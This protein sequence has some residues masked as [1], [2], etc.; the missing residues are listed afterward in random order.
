[1]SRES[2][3]EALGQSIETVQRLLLGLEAV[4][5]DLAGRLSQC[6]GSSRTFWVNRETRYRADS[7]RIRQREAAASRETWVRQF[8]VQDMVRLGWIG[9]FQSP[10]EAAEECLKLFGVPDVAAWQARFAG[11]AASAAF[12]I[13]AAARANPGA[14]TAWLRWAE[15]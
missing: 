1:I 11:A 12:R 8:P 2:L 13:S 3:A 6:L 10:S 7:E 4:D 15:L 5:D 14:V 9:T